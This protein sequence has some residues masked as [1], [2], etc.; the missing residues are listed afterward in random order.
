MPPPTKGPS[1]MN[2]RKRFVNFIEAISLIFGGYLMGILLIG[3]MVMILVEVLTRYIVQNPL[4]IAEQFGGYILVAM[5]VLALGYTWKERGHVRVTFLVDKLSAKTKNWLRLVRVILAII[6]SLAL[7]KASYDMV[8]Y[9]HFFGKMSDNWVRIPLKWPQMVLIVGS[10][11]LFIQLIA[12]LV[13]A[14][15]KIIQSREKN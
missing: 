11:L 13:K 5:C 1:L 9:A 4:G 14:I 7:I 12:E 6:F 8:W 2:K 15:D 10:V 3:L